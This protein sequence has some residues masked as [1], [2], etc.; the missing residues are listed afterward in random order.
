MLKQACYRILANL[1]QTIENHR[2]LPNGD[3]IMVYSMRKVGSTT[4]TSTLRTAGHIVYKHHCIDPSLN[5]EFRLALSRTGFKP[6]HWLTDGENFRKRLDKWR[7]KR[8]KAQETG[9]LKIFTFVKD[10]LAIALSDFFMQLFEFMP[11]VVATRGLDNVDSLK[12]YFQIVLQAAIENHSA[13][14]VTHYL[15]KLGTMPH[16]WFD[17]EL[18]MTMGIDVLETAFP[19]EAGYG[20]YRGHDCDA[21][22]I[23]TD[24]LSEV[25][26]DAIAILTGNKPTSLIEK[27]IRAKTPQREFYRSLVNTMSLPTTL[28]GQFYNQPWLNHFYNEAEIEAMM[29]K[30][31][32]IP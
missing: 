24:K 7:L 6:Q 5:A 26:L 15:G 28:V 32:R 19:I 25:A 18:K 29:K 2:V 30:W 31:S 1:N 4:L 14:P 8:D 17:R 23:R 10:P 12:Q 22:L 20:I 9:R 27:N 11:H 3:P 13:D 16:F 21:V